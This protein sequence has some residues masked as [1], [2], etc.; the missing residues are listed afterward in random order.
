MARPGTLVR[1]MAVALGLATIAAPPALATDLGEAGGIFYTSQETTASG[2]FLVHSECPTGSTV[3][4]GGVDQAFFTQ[5]RPADGPDAGNRADDSWVFVVYQG[6]PAPATAYAICSTIDSD[7][8]LSRRK[9]V[10]PGQTKVA[11]VHCTGGQRVVGGGGIIATA[12]QDGSR[13]NS[14]TPYDAGDADHK[15]DDGWAIRVENNN[16]SASGKIRAN[17]VCVDARP[18]YRTV[19]GNLP[20]NGSISPAPYCP[21][22]H[23]IVGIGIESEGD[24]GQGF[25]FQLIPR[26]DSSSPMA[27][28]D[29]VPDDYGLITITNSPPGTEAPF[30]ATGICL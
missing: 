15:R 17:A 1:T 24:A 9:L 7:Y 28:A 30:T 22:T 21:T 19:T 11:R 25:P 20:A 27:D 23:H 4:G 26:D 3:L 2:F 16:L 13:I 10:D 5:S 14:T 6:S 8:V 18:K 29:S 12:I